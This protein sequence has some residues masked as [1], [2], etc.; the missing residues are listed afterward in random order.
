[1]QQQHQSQHQQQQQQQQ[2]Q[3]AMQQNQQ[4]QQPR[5]SA[6]QLQQMQQVPP[7][8]Y[9]QA[10]SAFPPQPRPPPASPS[11]APSRP[12]TIMSATSAPMEATPPTAVGAST[13]HSAASMPPPTLMPQ[14]PQPQPHP[15]TSTPTIA[16]STPAPQAPAVQLDQS[17]V[18]EYLTDERLGTWRDTGRSQV[19]ECSR[20]ACEASDEMTL[21]TI[22]QETIQSVLTARIPAL[23]AGTLIKAIVGDDADQDAGDS[24]TA[25][26]SSLFLDTLAIITEAEGANPILRPFISSSGVSPMLMR[27]Q[28]DPALLQSLGMIRDTF[29]KLSIR[30]QTNILYRQSNYNLLREESEGYSKLLTELFTTSNNEAPSSEVV[31]ATFERVKAMVGAFNM[32]VGRV[33]DVTLDVFAAVLVKQYRFFVKFLRVSSWWPRDPVRADIPEPG[34]PRWALP[35]YEGWTTTEEDRQAASASAEE[36]DRRFWTRVREVGL[37][38]WFEIGRQ[39]PEQQRDKAAMDAVTAADEEARDWIEQTGTLPPQG[40]RVAAQLLGFKLRFYSSPDRDPTDVLPDN[41]IYLAALLIKIGFIS[42]R[43]L[44]PHL[45]RSDDEMAALKEKKT[46]EKIAR[47]LANRPGAGVVNA[48]MMSGA[49]GDEGAPP[50]R[51]DGETRTA[52]PVNGQQEDQKAAD[53]DDKDEPNDQKVLLLKSLLA[54]GALPESL[55][56]L[57]KFPWLLDLYPEL[58]D[59]IHRIVHHSLRKVYAAVQP[60]ATLDQSKQPKRP[61]IPDTSATKK[62]GAHL[63]PAP[64]RRVL[65]WAQL[66]R[67]DENDDTSFRYY[68]DDWS[69]NVPVC[70]DVDDVFALCNTL[71]NLSGVKIGGDPALL[72][73]LARIGKHSLRNDT[74]ELNRNRWRD[75]CKQMLVPALSLTKQNPGVVNEVFDLLSFFPRHIRFNMYAEWYSGQTSRLPDIKS[76]FD[77]AKAKTKAALKRLSKTNVKPMARTLAK[78][79]YANPGIL[80]NVAITQIEAYDNLIDVIVEGAR[81]F[82]FLGYDILIW[83]LITSLGQK[84]RSRVQQGGL[85]TSRWLNSLSSFIG[86]IYQRY[87][88][89]MDPL[90]ILQYVAEQ[91]H[92]NNSTDLIVLEQLITSMAGIVTEA[93]LNEAQVQAMAGG[94]ELHSMVL[95]QLLDTRHKMKVQ[96]RRLMRS[97]TDSNLAGRLLILIAQSRLTCVFTA[98]DEAANELKLLGNIF[99]EIHRVLTQYLDLLRSNLSPDEFSNFVPNAPAL[100]AQYGLTHEVAFWITRPSLDARIRKHNETVRQQQQEARDKKAAQQRAGDADQDTEMLDEGELPAADSESSATAS[101]TPQSSSSSTAPAQAASTPT[102]ASDEPP[103]HPVLNDLMQQL[104]G[105][106]AEETYT[107]VGLPFFTTFWQ[108]SLYDIHIPQKQYEE[109]MNKQRKRSI[110]ISSA[111]YDHNSDAKRRREEEKKEISDLS[112]RILAEY[113]HH[114]KYYEE[115][116]ARLNREKEHWFVGMKGRYVELNIALLE[117]CLLPRLLL[118]PTDAFFCFKMLKFLHASGTTC[119]RTMGLIDQLFNDKRLIAL[120]FQCT[121]READN[122]GRFLREVLND[123]SRWHADKAVYVKEAHGSKNLLPGFALSVGPDG[124]PTVLLEYEDFRRLLY[125]WHRL[126]CAAL[127][128]CL[129]S[130]EYMH[131]R[132]TI[133]VLKAVVNV[134]PSVDWMGNDLRGLV[135]NL[136]DND[137]RDDVK[138][139]AASL[140]GDFNRRKPKWVAADVFHLTDVKKGQRP[141]QPAAAEAKPIA[142]ES[143]AQ[144]QVPSETPSAS[145]PSLAQ[146]SK[147]EQAEEGEIQA[148]EIMQ[149]DQ[150]GASQAPDRSLESP[151]VSVQAQPTEPVAVRS[152]GDHVRN[153]PPRT[154]HLTTPDVTSRPAAESMH[155]L[156]LRPELPRHQF[157]DGRYRREPDGRYD[158]DWQGRPTDQRQ[159]RGRL[160]DR[161]QGM[162]R[163]DQSQHHEMP[164]DQ[165]GRLSPH[166]YRDEPGSI[167]PNRLPRGRGRGDM[168]QPNGPEMRSASS[169]AQMQQARAYPFQHDQHDSPRERPAS[170]IT[171]PRRGYA[172]YDDVARDNRRHQAQL[173]EA[174]SARPPHA[175]ARLN[176]EARQFQPQ[177]G[178]ELSAGP[179]TNFPDGRLGQ[180]TPSQPPGRATQEV[181]PPIDK[182][183]DTNRSLDAPSGLRAETRNRLDADDGHP[184]EPSTATPA[185]IQ[186]QS[187]ASAQHQAEGIS[188]T[189]G[190]VPLAPMSPQSPD[191]TGGIH[192]DRLRRVLVQEDSSAQRF[193]QTS[194]GPNVPSGPRSN[195]VATRPPQRT[196][197]RQYEGGRPMRQHVQHVGP[198]S[199]QSFSDQASEGTTIRGRGA[200]RQQQ[201]QQLASASATLERRSE[202]FPDEP[203]SGRGPDRVDGFR[204]MRGDRRSDVGDDFAD[205]QH[206]SRP[207]SL[208]TETPDRGGDRSSET[209]GPRDRD[210][211]TRDRARDRDRDHD[212]NR[213]HDDEHW[214][215]QPDRRDRHRDRDRDRDRERDRDRDRTRLIGRDHERDRGNRDRLRDAPA[216]RAARAG[217][218]EP[219]RR[220][221]PFSDVNREVAD[222]PGRG[223][224]DM[225]ER[226]RTRGPDNSNE[227]ALPD[228]V[229]QGVSRTPDDQ[230]RDREPRGRRDRGDGERADREREHSQ[231][232]RD[233]DG[234][235][236][237]PRDRG[238][239]DRNRGR[240]R[241]RERGRDIADDYAQDPAGASGNWPRKRTRPPA[242]EGGFD[243][244]GPARFGHDPK[245]PR[246]GH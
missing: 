133:S 210:N 106:L 55:Y 82:T 153:L 172:A 219:V 4:A 229:S 151:V 75:L 154:A 207:G 183:V 132:N 147:A 67:D 143:P 161:P 178:E 48:L 41:L 123:L 228:P 29:F 145:M 107:T 221:E 53:A 230:Q 152:A 30:K 215:G 243:G 185:P 166:D 146:E 148:T 134:Y 69:D 218:G 93:N 204:Q 10:Q 21:S 63:G 61:L 15:L 201:H 126:F 157:Q 50:P 88:S 199:T 211:R 177:H 189:S 150:T 191:P 209:S 116:R 80:I 213:R 86:K 38:A 120:I 1:H 122:L 17:Y 79:A 196:G 49:L 92:Q 90:P 164:I 56:I 14:Q 102:T 97:L 235:R 155:N 144:S 16:T 179:R 136:R 130:G 37:P 129:N 244:P 34:L 174:G 54:I 138:I 91:L 52:T 190:A 32:D 236:E 112:D 135:D 198:S 18:F 165:T 139:P 240:D 225:Q 33:L 202:L 184:N 20:Q 47:E 182:N 214:R 26:L 58:P 7:S 197:D 121:S 192:P 72:V 160:P 159:Q 231:R 83:A 124:K 40:N 114:L 25:K 100:I 171:S 22:F 125:K 208:R 84:G 216:D 42:L 127:K 28:L 187:P 180:E 5:P 43:D 99:D 167:D 222:M 176:P 223:R 246:R 149:V 212:A 168:L 241:D 195:V 74:S 239:R 205:Q 36:R 11:P 23:E 85:F 87:Y 234:D 81:Y 96:S 51:A 226:G 64:Q 128:T 57:G 3:Q 71:L 70:Q 105:S 193:S 13:P 77:Q 65:R 9:Q 141:S 224:R 232:E 175:N 78:I 217:V 45:W 2:Q 12:T 245:R 170:R 8:P 237:R 27:Q 113:K 186:P 19:L 162:R 156:P 169:A 206:L 227:M 117:Q 203:M 95:L 194:V 39:V 68:W 94:E 200:M 89:I 115:V 109:E 62:T 66:D 59:F 104:K 76:A 140:I 103:W 44:Y 137:P 119:F 60:P 24:A 6:Q 110:A 163:Y 111:R 46:K 173:P 181:G 142:K 188:A 242:M 108:L 131:I 220:I 31:K 73:K 35:E 233:R 158:N 238:D 118:S 101:D 98:D